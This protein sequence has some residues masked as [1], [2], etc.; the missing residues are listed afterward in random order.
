MDKILA[1][2]LLTAKNISKETAACKTVEEFKRMVSGSDGD[3]I[4]VDG[5]HCP[6]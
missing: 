3:N 6:V 5:T 2:V 4:F 1:V